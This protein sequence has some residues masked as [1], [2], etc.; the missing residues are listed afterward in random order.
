M[1]R[2]NKII[3]S[4][5]RKR[6]DDSRRSSRSLELLCCPIIHKK[7]HVVIKATSEV[8]PPQSKTTQQAKKISFLK[9][10]RQFGFLSLCKEVF[11]FFF[12]KK[13]EKITALRGSGIMFKHPLY[14]LE[15]E[16]NKHFI[17]FCRKVAVKQ[18]IVCLAIQIVKLS[19]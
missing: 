10:D 11:L 12:F 17:S 4:P 19:D 5:V 16:S 18:N 3:R 7:A 2:N 15:W 1:N 14:K 9:I 6:L 8:C 13:K